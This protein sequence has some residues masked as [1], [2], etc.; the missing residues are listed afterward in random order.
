MRDCANWVYSDPSV[1]R[2]KNRIGILLREVV[3]LSQVWMSHADTILE[4]PR[5]FDVLATTDSIPYAAFRNNGEGYPL[6]CL[7]FHPEVY[8]SV[9]GKKILK[10][11]LIDICGCSQSWTSE[12]F[13]TETVAKLKAQIG[14]KKVI[15]A[16]SGGVDSTVAATLVHRAI[17]KNL[18]GIFVDNG[19][20]RKD[21]FQQQCRHDGLRVAQ[22]TH[23][24][25]RSGEIPCRTR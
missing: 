1:R 24:V 22:W 11:F 21:E 6:Y 19:V 9:E 16:L 3:E 14:N 18:F 8:H 20:L 25:N 4:L 7:Q 23:P 17:G 2:A 12:N 5:G 10:N 13:I 15:M